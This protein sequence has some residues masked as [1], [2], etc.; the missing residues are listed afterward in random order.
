MRAA[1]RLR[2]VAGHALRSLVVRVS[3]SRR[4]TPAGALLRRVL[5]RS[6][7]FHSLHHSNR[8]NSRLAASTLHGWQPRAG[9]LRRRYDRIGEMDRVLREGWAAPAEGPAAPARPFNGKVLMALH[10]SLPYDAAGYAVRSQQIIGNLRGLGLDVL[11]ATRVGYPWDLQKHM[12][13]PYRPED[14]VGGVRYVRLSDPACTI[15]D[16]ES[17]YIEGY[18]RR[19]A[20]LA[21]PWGAGVIH[22]HSNYLDGLAAARAARRLGVRSVFEMR[23]LWHLSRGVK[24]PWFEGSDHQR[25]C[26]VMEVA[27]AREAGAVACISGALRRHMAGKGVPEGKMHVV[28]NAVDPDRFRP[29]PPDPELRR[30][31]R[32]EGRVVVGFIGSLTRYEGLDRLLEAVF[33]LMARGVPLSVVICGAGYMEP[34]LR[35]MAA[36]SPHGEHVHLEGLV[37]FDR[38]G[39]YYS[40]IDILPLPRSGDP[41]CRLVPPLK[42]LEIMAMEKALVVSDLPPLL[43]TVEPERTGLVCR[44]DDTGSLADAI[45]RLAG[46]EPMRRGLG[47]AARRWVLENRSWKD[48]ARKYLPLYEGGG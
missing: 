19:L 15:G 40:V 44:A 36:G 25:Y 9:L 43:E 4:D 39:A 18:A 47:A 24:E 46:S 38:V 42:V 8:G 45:G 23:G 31:L 20:E 11:A 27:A 32:L 30:R 16:A 33:G 29:A 12:G 28:P 41:V 10:N 17:A 34:V 6:P 5:L 3:Q 35:E 22:A 26:D 13:K 14:E 7:M 48:V 1:E 21:G 2:T 37:P